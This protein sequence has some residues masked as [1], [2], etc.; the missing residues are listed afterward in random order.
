MSWFGEKKKGLAE[1]SYIVRQR[2]RKSY[3]LTLL[4]KELCY[5]P[6][7][8][9]ENP[10]LPLRHSVVRTIEDSPRDTK[11]QRGK[12]EHH[13]IEIDLMA[14]RKSGSLLQRHNSRLCLLYAL[15]DQIERRCSCHRPS[16][17][18]CGRRRRIGTVREMT[19]TRIDFESSAGERN[20]CASCSERRSRLDEDVCTLGKCADIERLSL[21]GGGSA[22]SPLSC[23]WNKVND[24]SWAT[25]CELIRR[26]S[27]TWPLT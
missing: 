26:I 9:H 25:K 14:P 12:H 10:H 21:S 16:S 6:G 4:E 27:F 8:N 3:N 7:N 17:W 1:T 19:D 24:S 22:A 13:G 11:P 5:W 20:S 18:R 2:K 23:V 15:R